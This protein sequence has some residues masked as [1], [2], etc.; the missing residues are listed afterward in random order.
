M[1][2]CHVAAVD[3]VAVRTCPEDGAVAA[4]TATVVVADFKASAYQ[5][6]F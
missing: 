3:E 4:L 6:V 5:D 2:V 1:G